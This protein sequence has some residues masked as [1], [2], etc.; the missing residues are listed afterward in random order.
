MSASEVV[1]QLS[2]PLRRAIL[3]LDDQR[4]T[5]W[6][7]VL[8]Q[9]PQRI[10]LVALGITEPEVKGPITLWFNIRLTALGREVKELLATRSA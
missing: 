1:K 8:R 6:S 3:A 5:D 2:K 7:R 9:R 4:F 10:K